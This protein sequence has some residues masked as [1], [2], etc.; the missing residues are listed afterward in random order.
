MDR[1]PLAVGA[2]SFFRQPLTFEWSRDTN[3]VGDEVGKFLI[4]GA[5]LAPE[6]QVALPGY[7]P[8]RPASLDAGSLDAFLAAPIIELSSSRAEHA[9]VKDVVRVYANELGGVHWGL[10]EKTREL[11]IVET[12]RVRAPRHLDWSMIAIAR[13]AYRAIEPVLNRAAEELLIVYH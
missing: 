1:S 13:I 5:G 6:L 10:A 12:A 2:A 11:D 9:S 7:D 3:V 4:S 8:L